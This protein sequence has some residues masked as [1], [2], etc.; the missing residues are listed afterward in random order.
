MTDSSHQTILEICTATL[1]DVLIAQ[2]AGAQRVELNSSLSVGGLTPL[3]GTVQLV[4]EQASIP[5]IAMARPRESGFCYSV[6]EFQAMVRDVRWLLNAGVQ[7]I[8]FGVLDHQG[9]IDMDRCQQITDLT[10]GERDSVF[11]RAFDLVRDKKQAIQNLVECGVRRV[12]TSGGQKTAWQGRDQIRELVRWVNAEGIPIEIIPAGGIRPDHVAALVQH[13]AADQVHAG[14]GKWLADGAW[15]DDCEFSF[16]G[17]NPE[18]P[19][20]FR[21]SCG[22]TI[23]QML[24]RIPRSGDSAVKP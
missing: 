19:A 23:G 7:G 21:Q 14:P 2:A 1:D 8:A 22:E 24:N 12:M 6:N 16:Y 5:V 10:G 13:T 9:Q 4:V 3:P 20:H 15:P 17:S 11:H 18:N